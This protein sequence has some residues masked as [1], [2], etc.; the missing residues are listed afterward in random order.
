MPHAKEVT[1]QTHGLDNNKHTIADV[2]LSDGIHINHTL[3]KDG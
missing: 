2:F 1:V 3:F